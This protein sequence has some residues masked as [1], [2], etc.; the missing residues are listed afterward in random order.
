MD[1][2]T[3]SRWAQSRLNGEGCNDYCV[4]GEKTNSSAKLTVRK[5]IVRGSAPELMWLVLRTLKEIL[6]GTEEY[7]YYKKSTAGGKGATSAKGKPEKG[8]GK[9][10]WVNKGE[11]LQVVKENLML[12]AVEE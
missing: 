2:L 7:S 12:I 6:E 1:S 5:T 10:S 9:G 3:F 8:N 11:Y 4:Q